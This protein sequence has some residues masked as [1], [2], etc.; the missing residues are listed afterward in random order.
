[1]TY[2]QTR[3]TD[4]FAQT[5]APDALSKR[6]ARKLLQFRSERGGVPL[7]VSLQAPTGSTDV[8]VGAYYYQ[9]VS[10]NFDA[11]GSI[12]FETAVAHHPDRPGNDFR[13]GNTATV[14]V[15][16][17]YEEIPQLQPVYANPDGYQLL[18]PWTATVGLSYAF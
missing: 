5:Q 18:P 15:G 1:M 2:G 9:A 11:F 10:Q 17:R 6:R 13:R 16:L 4:A 8:M 14:S 7:D 12:R 3:V